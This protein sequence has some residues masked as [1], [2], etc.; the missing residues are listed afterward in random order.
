MEIFK[1]HKANRYFKRNLKQLIQNGDH[2]KARPKYKDGTS[3]SSVSIYQVFEKYDTRKESVIHNF[4]PTAIKT[5]I[6]EILWIYQDQSNDLNKAR[7]R[8]INWWNEF[9]VGD[10]TIGEAYGK[11]I[12]KHHMMKPFLNDLVKDSYSKRHILSMWQNRDLKKQKKKNGLFPCAFLT[13]WNITK[14]RFIDVTLIQRSNDFITAGAINKAQYFSFALAVAG[15]VSFKT[16][17]KHKI[18]FFSHY[19]HDLHVYDRHLPALKELNRKIFVSKFNQ[20]IVL[21]EDKDFF[22]YKIEDFK[23]ISK[24]IKS[25]KSPIEIAV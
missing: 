7:Q 4:R 9:D 23:I 19:V 21:E 14:D 5:G 2:R 15:H 24:K 6:Q 22:D 12:K 3:A 20:N 13:M 16:G 8:K 11:T 17:I 25:L 18:R 10:G 1:K